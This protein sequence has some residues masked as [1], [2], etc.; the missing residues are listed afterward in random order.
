[1]SYVG[2]SDYPNFLKTQATLVAASG[3]TTFISLNYD[4]P[5]VEVYKNGARLTPSQYDAPDGYTLTLHSPAVLGDVIEVVSREENAVGTSVTS[6]NGR[7]GTVTIGYTDIANVAY[8][9]GTG[10]VA[11][12]LLPASVVGALSYQ[13]TWNA[14]SGSAPSSSP[15]KGHY[16]TV[17]VQG[18]TVLDGI[19]QWYVG[20]VA[21]WNGTD[22]DRLDGSAGE[23][24]SFNGRTGAV[25]LT[26]SDITTSFGYTPVQQGTGFGQLGNTVKLGWAGSRLKATVDSTDLGN[27]VFDT[28]LSAQTLDGLSD[29]VITGPQV[30]QGVIWNGSQWV[31]GSASTWGQIGGSLSS[32]TDLVNTLATKYDKTGGLITGEVQ[33]YPSG[34]HTDL[35]VQTWA[36]YAYGWP[37]SSNVLGASNGVV[38]SSSY[39]EIGIPTPDLQITFAAFTIPYTAKLQDFTVAITCQVLNN[40]LP[41]D[42]DVYITY[43]G[44][45]VSNPASKTLIGNALTQVNFS[46]SLW[47]ITE[48]L[49]AH[50]VS[51]GFGVLISFRTT[52]IAISTPPTVNVDSVKL[53]Y[54]Y[55]VHGNAAG[56]LLLGSAGYNFLQFDGFNYN[57]SEADLLVNGYKAITTTGG[58]FI[59]PIY[60]S[61]SPTTNMEAAT[62]QY[63]D[64]IKS[65][66]DNPGS[67][68]LTTGSGYKR[69]PGNFLIQWIFYLPPARIGNNIRT[70]LSWPITFANVL[71]ANLSSTSGTIDGTGGST[72][73][74]ISYLTTS[75]VIVTENYNQGFWTTDP[76]VDVP[77]G[78]PV[79]A[80]K[81]GHGFIVWGLGTW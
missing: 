61:S 79:G 51:S 11:S 30:N 26:S 78:S 13:G 66:A 76:T 48:S 38:S 2:L 81:Y 20:D 42:C 32:Q 39:N 43:A 22:W 16:W 8:L 68:S 41:C 52:D 25:V 5:N 7:T 80:V 46:S 63:V 31:N 23:V 19:N 3:Q 4:P 56:T 65:Y 21:I 73:A 9:D 71:S 57:L 50:K 62:K 45:I 49:T 35:S 53:T 69:L 60:L 47:T 12:N 77:V 18:T 75:E 27:I 29:V 14:S 58:T 70:T 54:N 28:Q 15:P 10:K 59:K 67:S 44:V 33:I 17:A 24:L 40:T 34:L 36:G 74:C 55:T 37:S 64:S 6:V 72:G 1:M